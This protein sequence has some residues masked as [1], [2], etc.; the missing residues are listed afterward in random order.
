M[1]DEL[2]FYIL[3][4]KKKKIYIESMAPGSEQDLNKFPRYGRDLIKKEAFA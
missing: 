4:K 2:Q 3:L 1:C